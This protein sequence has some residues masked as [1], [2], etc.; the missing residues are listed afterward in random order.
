[1]NGIM[2]NQVHEYSKQTGNHNRNDQ[3]VFVIIQP[4]RGKNYGNVNPEK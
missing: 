1:M 4:G 2:T 3:Q